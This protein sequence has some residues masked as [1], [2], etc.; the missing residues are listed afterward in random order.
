MSVDFVFTLLLYLVCGVL[1]V[2]I[3]VGGSDILDRFPRWLKIIVRIVLVPL[4]M[5]I[6]F[7]GIIIAAIYVL[8][9]YIFGE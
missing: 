1:I 8:K 4:W 5:P 7:V 3:I 9:N 6:G 2:G